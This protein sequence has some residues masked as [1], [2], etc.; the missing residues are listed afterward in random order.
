MKTGGRTGPE[1]L[2]IDT[3]VRRRMQ[4]PLPFEGDR[5]STLSCWSFYDR[6]M[7]HLETVPNKCMTS[8][9]GSDVANG[10]NFCNDSELW[11]SKMKKLPG[12]SAVVSKPLIN[13]EG[14]E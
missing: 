4:G 1:V 9:I 14:L 8:I 10:N 5:L 13:I 6:R 2:L 3:T 11:V 12:I 7:I